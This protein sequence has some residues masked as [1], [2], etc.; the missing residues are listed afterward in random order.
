[1]NLKLNLQRQFLSR[2]R[3]VVSSENLFK[4]SK[5]KKQNKKYGQVLADIC[6]AVGMEVVEDNRQFSER[7]IFVLVKYEI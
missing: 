5:T 4:P 6:R 1:M 7:A 3:L 2:V